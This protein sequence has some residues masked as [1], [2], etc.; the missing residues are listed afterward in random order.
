MQGEGSPDVVFLSYEEANAEE[1]FARLLEFAP[2]AKRVHGVEGIFHAYRQALSR[3][4]TPRFF[5]V[6]GDNWILDGFV[7]RAPPQ[8]EAAEVYLWR[9][10]NPVNGLEL[11]NG[12]LKLVT[13]DAILSM[14]KDAVDLSNSM[15]A[16]R[17]LVNR[18]ATETRFNTTPFLAWRCGFRECAKFASGV[19]RNPSVPVVQIW[20]TVGAETRNGKWCMLGARMGGEY[21]RRFAGT[22]KLRFINDMAWMKNAFEKVERSS[23]AIELAMASKSGAK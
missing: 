8:R 10:R 4:S 17:R 11:F 22:N 6:D 12:A 1:N 7:F 5:V 23:K 16:T 9:A 21:G 14:D 2:R 13:R 3:V 18:V 20:Q 15:K 19:L